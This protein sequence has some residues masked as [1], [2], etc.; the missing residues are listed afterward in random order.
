[1]KEMSVH[2]CTQ[3]HNKDDIKRFILCTIL[4]IKNFQNKFALKM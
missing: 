3:V 2:K 1:M 4:P